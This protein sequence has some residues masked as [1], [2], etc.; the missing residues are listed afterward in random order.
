MNIARRLSLFVISAVVVGAVAAGPIC[1]F[2]SML[3]FD[4]L[5]LKVPIKLPNVTFLWAWSIVFLTCCLGFLWGL[6]KQT[7]SSKSRLKSQS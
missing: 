5:L 2:W 4:M 1:F 3:A 7:S 6:C